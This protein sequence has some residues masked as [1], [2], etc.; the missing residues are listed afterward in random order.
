[1]ESSGPVD[2]QSLGLGVLLSG[3]AAYLAITLFL[4]FIERIGMWPFVVYRLMLGAVIFY[5]IA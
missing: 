1:V 5:L 2:W 3:I 4:R